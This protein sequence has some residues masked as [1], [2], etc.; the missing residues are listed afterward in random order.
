MN[1][2]SSSQAAPAWQPTFQLDYKPL[3]ASASVWVWEKGEGSRVSQSLVHNLFL[4]ED[5]HAFEEG[6]EESMGRRL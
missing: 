1:L 3:L 5:M 4:L 6:T 2:A